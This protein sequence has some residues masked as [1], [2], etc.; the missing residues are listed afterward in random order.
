MP[1]ENTGVWAV[2]IKVSVLITVPSCQSILS[3][4]VK[5]IQD[6]VLLGPCGSSDPISTK[7]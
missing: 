4:K 7:H 6:E 1:L 3:H 2:I 5:L